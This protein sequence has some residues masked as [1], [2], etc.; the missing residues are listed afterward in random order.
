[1]S[2]DPENGHL[3][4]DVALDRGKMPSFLKMPPGGERVPEGLRLIS[5]SGLSAPTPTETAPLTFALPEVPFRR[6][7]ISCRL[8]FPGPRPP[9]FFSLSVAGVTF[10]G[11]DHL[12]DDA[13]F[14]GEPLHG[15]ER[16]LWSPQKI[17]RALFWE[18]ELSSY[19]KGWKGAADGFGLPLDSDLDMLIVLDSE[20]KKAQANVAGRSWALSVKR[21]GSGPMA[22]EFRGFPVLVLKRL[23]LEFRL[24][25][26]E[27]SR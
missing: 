1:M 25:A 7:E 22:I 12:R 21:I 11:I 6:L 24:A 20:R 2:H 10:L 18:G 3:I 13:A 16:P 5:D 4:I 14:R 23:R 19:L 9:G 15:L 17:G 8:R 27:S 26:L